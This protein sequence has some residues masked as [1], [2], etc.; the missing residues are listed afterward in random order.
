MERYPKVFVKISHMW[1]LSKQPYPYPDAQAQVKK[2]YDKFGAKRL[3]WGTDWP[4]SLRQLK[5][6]QAVALYRDYMDFFTPADREWI[7]GKTVQQV[8]PFRL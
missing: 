2:L 4:I 8:W 6:E 1:T 3:M 7:L 5:Y